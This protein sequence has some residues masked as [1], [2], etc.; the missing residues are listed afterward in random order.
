MATLCQAPASFGA[1][2]EKAVGR[3]PTRCFDLRPRFRY[4]PR[5]PRRARAGTVEHITDFAD[6]L[7]RRER[8][9]QER[10][11]SI[12][13]TSPHDVIVRV[14]RHEEH[15]QHRP[16]G[17]QLLAQ[18]APAH[19]R[20]DD[21]GEHEMD[22]PLM[23]LSPP[24]RV[25]AIG[26]GDDLVAARLKNP[27]REPP[28][29]L[30]VFDEEDSLVALTVAVANANWALRLVGAGNETREVDLEG[31]S[32]PWFAVHRDVAAGRDDEGALE[33]MMSG[34]GHGPDGGTK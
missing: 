2:T 25:P 14:S 6:E 11:P 27:Q 33:L 13:D 15:L 5:A 17:A 29:M 32:V 20:H 28:Q 22:R 26:R 4:H 1:W 30:V 23:L 16:Q 10:G 24:Q 21:V 9:L 8:L 12:E 18:H 7:L 19:A 31:G 34:P 3:L